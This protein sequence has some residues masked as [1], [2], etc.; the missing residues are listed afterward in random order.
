MDIWCKMQWSKVYR[1]QGRVIPISR[2]NLTNE[3]KGELAQRTL[4]RE[5]KGDLKNS[6]VNLKIGIGITKHQVS[7]N[8]LYTNV[9]TVNKNSHS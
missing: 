1:K 3:F 4:V 2:L 9:F 6:L 8:L 5:H 7:I